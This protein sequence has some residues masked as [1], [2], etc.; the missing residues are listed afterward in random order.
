[1]EGICHRGRSWSLKPSL[2]L[3]YTLLG[4]EDVSSGLPAS[5]AMPSH[6]DRVSSLF[7]KS[8]FS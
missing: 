8:P 7:C 3:V 2:L 4:S 6:H 5:A 1:M